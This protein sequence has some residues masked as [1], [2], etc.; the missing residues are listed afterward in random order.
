MSRLRA[1]IVANY[2][3]KGWEALMSFAFLPFYIKYLGPEAYGI[4]GFVSL[5]QAWMGLLDLGVTPTLTREMARYEVGARSLKDTGNL[6]R[7][8]ETL[9]FG[10][11]LLILAGVALLSH[12]FAHSWF[13]SNEL[14]PDEIKIALTVSAGLIASRFCETIYRG[15]LFGL[16]R[17]VLAVAISSTVSGLR[18]GGSV[19]VLIFVEASLPA[20]FAWQI[21]CSVLSLTLLAGATY[22]SLGI[23]I[24]VGRF[25]SQ[26]L[27]S[28]VAYA[29]GVSLIG[30]L[31]LALTSIDKI[32]LSKLISLKVFGYYVFASKLGSLIATVSAPITTAVSP[33][34]MGAVGRGDKAEEIALFHRWA[35]II[36]GITF[37]LAIMLIFYGREI[38]FTWTGDRELAN[39]AGIFL[40]IIAIG[41]IMNTQIAMPYYVQL[42]HGKTKVTIL[43]NLITLCVFIPLAFLLIPAHGAMVVPWLWVGVATGQLVITAPFLFR[44]TIEGEQ[45]KW[46]VKDLALPIIGPMVVAA[47]SYFVKP[48]PSAD[49][50]T[51][52]SYILAVGILATLPNLI[53]GRKYWLQFLRRKIA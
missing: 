33:Q 12:F 52:G 53:A 15:S 48:A 25:S 31:A 22:R 8:I 35:R 7:S 37:P 4:V 46:Y 41:N 42:A 16:Q 44:N 40:Q 2:F 45:L 11:A 28:I 1:N 18:G 39:S 17:Q 47:A 51:W 9:T 43:S 27:K 6:L 24:F 3:G 38:I 14:S 30:L 29:G 23:S 50:I 49:Q 10:V 26:A 34:L 21:V 19:L 32:I 5:I 13:D 20:F 36:A